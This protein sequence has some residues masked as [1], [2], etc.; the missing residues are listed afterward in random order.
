M[1]NNLFVWLFGL[2]LL[3][4]A[5]GTGEGTETDEDAQDTTE[6]ADEAMDDTMTEEEV[7]MSGDNYEVVML[8]SEP[9]SPRKEMRGS[10]GDVD[11]V[12][13]YGSPLQKGRTLW[14]D[15]VPYGEV[16]RTGANEVTTIE[17]SQDV[18]VGGETLSAGKYGLFTI[19]GEDE[20][21]IIFNANSDMWGAMDYDEAEDVLRVTATPQEMEEASESMDF[22]MDGN[23]LVLKWGETM[24]PVEISA[25]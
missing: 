23:N 4:A 9:A 2:L 1:K 20:W 19:P 24:V 25:S 16:W 22:V 11:V 6:T 18:M 12:V 21:T 17:V 5:C 15:L 13:N 7:V 3:T 8:D 14:G 10:L